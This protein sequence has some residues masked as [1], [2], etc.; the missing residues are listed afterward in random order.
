MSDAPASQPQRGA[1][2]WPRTSRPLFGR[3]A[4]LAQVELAFREAGLGRGTAVVLA[5]EAGIGKTALIEQAIRAVPGVQVLRAAGAEF[6]SVLPFAALHQLCGPLLG[7]SETLPGPQRAALEA[8][9]GMRSDVVPERLLVGLAVLGLLADR[10]R[11]L[12]VACVIDDADWLDDESAHALAFVAR[13]VEADRIAIVFSVRDPA[14]AQ[15]LA[16]LRTIPVGAL[17]NEDAR[18]LL[19]SAIHAPIDARVRDTIIGEARGN[20]LALLELPRSAGSRRLA[21]GYAFPTRPVASRIE[22]S[23]L[24]RISALPAQTRGFLLVAAAEPLGDTVLL[25]DAIDRLGIDRAA[26][27]PAETADL[28]E[29]GGRVRFRHP[30]VRSAVYQAA[31][32]ADRRR[33][34]DALAAVTDAEREPDRRAWHR[35]QAAS[36]PDEDIALEL[37]A[38]AGRALTRGGMSA[39]A[40]FTERAAELTADPGRRASRMLVAAQFAQ[41]AGAVN[42]AL[43][44]LDEVQNDQLGSEQSGAVSLQRAQ[45]A[46][47]SARN[48]RAASML[49]SAATRV[50]GD[51]ARVALLQAFS[52]AMYAGRLGDG[53]LPEVAGAGLRELAH[54]AGARPVDHLLEGLATHVVLGY[55]AAVPAMRRAMAETLADGSIRDKELRW[56]GLACITTMDLWDDQTHAVLTE[57][58]VAMARKTGALSVLPLALNLNAI[59]HVLGGR[60]NAATVGVSEAYAITAAT[61]NAEFVY[62]DIVLSAWRGDRHRVDQL[63]ALAPEVIRRGEGRALVV[64][65][66]ATAVLNNGLGEYQLAADAATQAQ[67]HGDLG[68]ELFLPFELV[69]S[70]ARLGRPELAG[71]PMHTIERGARLCRTDAA[72]GVELRSRALLSTDA[73]A[74]VLFQQALARLERTTLRT[75]CARTHLVYGE[76]LRRH[77]RRSDAR[78]QLRTAHEALSEMGLTAFADRAARELEATGEHA[79]RRDRLFAD[80][81]TAR[82]LDI[83]SRAAG[84]ATSKEIAAALYLS[85]RTVDAHLRSIFRKSGVKSR[86]ELRNL[87]LA[88]PGLSG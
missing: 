14:S 49:L 75:Y 64:M 60:L 54:T 13:R 45:I 65:E 8:A 59:A 56:L 73:D 74:D 10:S 85:P 32:P 80:T 26:A 1:T 11:R 86:R 18:L 28:L 29:I 33:A 70:A 2:E 81:L 52:A 69:E 24:E 83:A 23:F 38:S 78:H 17:G 77:D 68:F 55:E 39:A 67:A 88:D 30:L 87:N 6:E 40:A 50:N 21:G 7:R 31:A 36:G 72:I 84:G 12:P 34:H 22:E 57:R 41:S 82:E 9:F 25:W 61:G 3:D 58:M 42:W 27:E 44:L 71:R 63:L 66:Y 35:A 15:Q 62:G 19:A 43:R 48:S 5:G 37:E 20:P 79:R 53:V 76:W 16:G 46:F 4:E 51:R 47:Q